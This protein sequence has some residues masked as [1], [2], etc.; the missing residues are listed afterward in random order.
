MSREK[1]DEIYRAKNVT[2]GL[3]Q[4]VKL[5]WR[6]PAD[7]RRGSQHSE[8]SLKMIVKPDADVYSLLAKKYENIPENA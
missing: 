5:S 4:G 7:Y 2:T 3:S 1:I 6:G 8:K